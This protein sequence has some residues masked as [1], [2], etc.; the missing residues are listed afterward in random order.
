MT[1]LK[2]KSRHIF[3]INRKKIKIKKNSPEES[4]SSRGQKLMDPCNLASQPRRIRLEHWM[5]QGIAAASGNGACPSVP[6]LIRSSSWS[7]AWRKESHAEVA[8][9]KG[10]AVNRI[11][12]ARWEPSELY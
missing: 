12:W 6:A 5:G 8:A 7:T 9:R 1:F 10:P 2:K 3:L 4:G 11:R